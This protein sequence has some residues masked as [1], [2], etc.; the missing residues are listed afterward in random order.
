M[1]RKDCSPRDL[2]ALSLLLGLPTSSA[3][4][5]GS[6]CFRGA[7]DRLYRNVAYVIIS[8]A[9]IVSLPMLDPILR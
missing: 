2:I 5:L 3:M 1:P 4:G 9:A 7:S 6:R 8:L